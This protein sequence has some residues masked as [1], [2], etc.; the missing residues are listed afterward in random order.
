MTSEVATGEDGL[1]SAEKKSDCEGDN[2]EIYS[3]VGNEIMAKI[4]AAE[5]AGHR[6][7]TEGGCKCYEAVIDSDLAKFPKV[8]REM[9]SDTRDIILPKAFHSLLNEISNPKFRTLRKHMQADQ[10]DCLIML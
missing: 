6:E 2:Q 1:C 8:T 3:Q 5:E 7:C 9:L 10:I 4:E